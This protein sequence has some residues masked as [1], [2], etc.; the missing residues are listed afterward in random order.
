MDRGQIGVR[1]RGSKGIEIDFYYLGQRCREVIKIPPTKANLLF[2]QRKRETIL[3]EIGISTFDYSAHFPKS[4]R[5]ATL[6][7]ASNKTVSQAL[8]EFLLISQR[9]CAPSTTRDYQS[10]VT[11][12][13]KPAFGDCLLRNITA[14][15]I[16]VWMSGLLISPKRIKNVLVPLKGAL[17]SAFQDGI[18]DRDVSAQIPSLSHRT[19]EPSPFT[20]SEIKTILE[21][22]DEQTRNLFQFAFFS[23]LRT[24][25]LIALEWRD[26]DFERGIVRVRRAS[27]RKIVKSPKTISGERDVKL[28]SPAVNALNAQKVFTFLANGRIFH[29]PKTNSPWETDGQ[30]RKTAWIPILKSANIPYRNPYQTRHTYASMLLSAGE[31]P[32]WVSYQ[33][34]H[35]DWAMIRKTYGRWIP[36]MNPVAGRKIEDL[37]SQYGQNANNPL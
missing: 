1:A 23:G 25:E 3:Y 22:S 21:H 6:G 13:L 11:H 37:W 28:L 36:D 4:R 32:M 8:H 18:I 33:M 34:G 12:H 16:K 29:N 27:V 17:H 15:Q 30:I 9:T 24:S 10:A 5:A 20:P 31:D 19:K 7:K 26:V 2:A 35:A 14:T